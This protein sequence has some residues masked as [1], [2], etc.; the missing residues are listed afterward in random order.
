VLEALRLSPPAAPFLRISDTL[1][2]ITDWRYAQAIKKGDTLY[3]DIASASRDPTRFP[4]PDQIKLDRPLNSYLPFVD[5]AYGPLVREIVVPGLV[6]QLRVLAKLEGLKKAPGI[7][8]R[9]KTKSENGI[10]SFLSEAQDEWVP[11]P[12]SKL[13]LIDLYILTTDTSAGMKLHF[14]SP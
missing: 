9:W 7:Q 11:F 12:T 10:V 3:L 13:S 8:G 14:I 4:D 5:G 1:P 6:A 2:S